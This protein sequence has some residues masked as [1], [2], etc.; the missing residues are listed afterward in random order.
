MAKGT[1]A[2]GVPVLCLP[3]DRWPAE[4]QRR[5]EL[6][7]KPAS[8][9]DDEG[10]ELTGMRPATIRKYA[11]GYGRWLTF[12]AQHDPVALDLAPAARIT[13]PRVKA[14]PSGLRAPWPTPLRP[15]WPPTLGLRAAWTS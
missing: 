3:V 10:G 6:A 14:P 8:L 11:K 15:A 5:W 7:C 13:T 9:F 4:D 12:L 2:T 1:S